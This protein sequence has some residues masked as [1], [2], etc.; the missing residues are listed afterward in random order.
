MLISMRQGAGGWIARIFMGILVLSF[1]VWG[2]A[3]F[4]GTTPETTL[5]EVSGKTISAQE[6]NAEFRRELTRMQ[7]Q[8]GDEFDTA[9]ARAL[10]LD[11]AVLRQMIMREMF[12]QQ[13]YELGLT[14]PD[15]IVAQSIKQDESFKDSLG[16]FNRM[17]LVRVLQDNGFTE[18]AYV[19]RIRREMT[20][21]QLIAAIAGGAP[22]PLGMVEEVL[23]RYNEKRSAD[24]LLIPQA[25]I[26]ALPKPSGAEIETFYNANPD[27][28]TAPETR[29]VTWLSVAP[30]DIA[31]K[32]V[33]SEAELQQEYQARLAE[34]TIVATRDLQQFVLDDRGEADKAMAEIKAGADFPTVAKKYSGLEATDLALPGIT[35]PELPTEA[36]EAIFALKQGESGGPFKNPFGW[37]IVKV[38]ALRDGRTPGF[39]EVRDRLAKETALSRAGD[40]LVELSTRLEDA[41]AGGATLEEAAKELGLKLRTLAAIDGKGNGSDGKPLAGLAPDEN[42]IADIF[43]TEAGAESDLRDSKDGGYY[44]LRVDKITASAV[45]PL[46]EVRG[47]AEAGWRAAR[48]VES[49]QQLADELLKQAR[50]GAPL[51]QIATQRKLKIVSAGPFARGYTDDHLSEAT[52]AKLFA[53]KTG[54]AITAA[55]P[56]GGYVLASLREIL[57]PDLKTQAEAVKGARKQLGDAIGND[58]LAQYQ[59]VLELR[60]QVSINESGLDSLFAEP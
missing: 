16:E 1:A 19:E 55:A 34:F 9:Q 29:S 42:F 20:R 5:A 56:A 23:I 33:V 25:A 3:D 4:L 15:A 39:A 17:N 32:I 37:Q 36:A 30:E 54:D 53:A 10:G 41:R 49:L 14:T 60:N 43:A 31:A 35:K 38:T 22:P 24:L 8:A 57:P 52:V 59:G 48:T 28:F 40:A 47:D 13:A 7:K 6:F 51:Q 46:A 18:A 21:R 45:R 58:L 26:G 27:Q 12:D 2:V 11:K 44:V 50:A